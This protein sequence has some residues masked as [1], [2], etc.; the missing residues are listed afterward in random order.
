MHQLAEQFAQALANNQ[1]SV[2]DVGYVIEHVHGFLIDN[3]PDVELW[4]TPDFKQIAESFYE[5]IDLS[6]Y[7][8][9]VR[10]H[11]EFKKG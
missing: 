6:D 7:T 3:H 10:A 9:Q 2:K 1:L 4:M 5:A 11:E 8:A